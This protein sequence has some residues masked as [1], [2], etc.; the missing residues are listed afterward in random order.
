MKIERLQ[1]RKINDAVM[2]KGAVWKGKTMLI[3]WVPGH[4]RRP[5][6][7]TSKS[8]LYVGTV[9]YAKLDKSAVRRNRMRRRCREALR[10]IAKERQELPT[11]QLLLCPRSAS[12]D[13]PFEL[14]EHDIRA[15]LHS[16]S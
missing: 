12:L 3:R 7:D 4:P 10:I 15:F 1:G 8:A 9:A 6:T 14:I 16:L 13:S 5:G 11:V 2:R